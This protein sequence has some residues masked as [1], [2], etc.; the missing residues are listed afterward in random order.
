MQLLCF[1]GECRLPIKSV[2]C[3]VPSLIRPV[4]IFD[5]LAYLDLCLIAEVRTA[6]YAEE[7]PGTTPA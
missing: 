6:C 4:P 3:P 2:F 7:R 1:D 5:F